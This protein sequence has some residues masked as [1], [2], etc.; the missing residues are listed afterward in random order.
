MEDRYWA[1]DEI[2]ELD[3]EPKP[4]K[5][6]DIPVLMLPSGPADRFETAILLMQHVINSATDRVWIASPYFIPD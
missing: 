6:S 4:A 1:T 5:D 3:W 2:L